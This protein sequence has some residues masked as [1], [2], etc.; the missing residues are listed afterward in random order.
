MK[1]IHTDTDHEAGEITYQI[2]EK[3]P[4]N[5]K[6]LVY[7]PK[8]GESEA[9]IGMN[10]EVRAEAYVDFRNYLWLDWQRT[11]LYLVRTQ[12]LSMPEAKRKFPWKEIQYPGRDR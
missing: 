2:V 12:D 6:F 5:G 10:P 9:A 8:E 1:F 7:F 4:D 11:L 3:G